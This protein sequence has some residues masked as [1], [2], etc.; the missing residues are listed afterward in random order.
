MD[1][2]VID[3]IL[4]SDKADEIENLVLK[5]DIK[6]ESC[7]Y[8]GSPK[9]F[10]WEDGIHYDEQVWQYIIDEEKERS[11]VELIEDNIS[12]HISDK[13][14]L[15]AKINKAQSPQGNVEWSDKLYGGPH[16]DSSAPGLITGIYYI[17]DSD[18]DTFL[19]NE[20]W[21]EE[22]FEEVGPEKLTLQTRITP[23]KNRL[24]LFNGHTYHSASVPSSGFRY[25][26]NINWA[27]PVIFDYDNMLF[28]DTA[29]GELVKL[30]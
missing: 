10:S 24:L 8:G 15:T 13:Q 11:I 25:V 17:H 21:D 4:P 9:S 14:Y 7:P 30:C 29:T 26:I 22:D 12:S 5:G 2:I 27:D 3:D 23:K 18:G 1:Y 19:F 6:W 20:I 16:F 28:E